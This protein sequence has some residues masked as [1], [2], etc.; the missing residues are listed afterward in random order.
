[1]LHDKQKNDNI[2]ENEE[3]MDEDSTKMNGNNINKL[4]RKINIPLDRNRAI[5]RVNITPLGSYEGLGN[6]RD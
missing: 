3:E 6:T 2:K 5:A 1:M 4:E